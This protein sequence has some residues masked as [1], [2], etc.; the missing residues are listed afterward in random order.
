MPISID[1]RTNTAAINKQLRKLPRE[2]FEPTIQTAMNRTLTNARRNAD[3]VT[4]Q[5]LNL[6][7][8]N[9]KNR[10]DSNG[11]IKGKR[12]ILTRARRNRLLA[13]ATVNRSSLLVTEIAGA[14]TSRGVKASGGRLYEGAFKQTVNGRSGFV[15]KRRG[16]AR[17]PTFAPR[18]G[19]RQEL[20]E[21][22]DYWII[23]P[24]GRRQ[25]LRVFDQQAQFRLAKWRGETR[26]AGAR[27]R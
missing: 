10:R 14:Q 4:A 12:T 21:N 7:L 1:V 18:I 5:K 11:N 20:D 23:G 24:G 16:R 17:R 25:Y 19:L 6:P 2:V 22:Y 27:V 9:I 15:L 3:K 8:T 13:R 26:R